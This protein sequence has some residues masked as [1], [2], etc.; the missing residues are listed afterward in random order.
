MV[1]E[2]DIDIMSWVPL[3]SDPSEKEPG[4]RRKAS[5]PPFSEMEW[6]LQTQDYIAVAEDLP[7]D[8]WDSIISKS[9]TPELDA[10]IKAAQEESE[11]AGR[12][13]VDDLDDLG[14]GTVDHVKSRPVI[15]R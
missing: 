11:S 5:Y 4:K 14:T 13:S 12:G 3:H 1:A 7:K 2:G 15:R 9:I 6:G 8:Q 10:A